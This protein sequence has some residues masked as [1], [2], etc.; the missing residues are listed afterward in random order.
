MMS[1][2]DAP[3]SNIEPPSTV[4]VP[5]WEAELAAQALDEAHARDE[6]ARD[7]MKA[8]QLAQRVQLIANADLELA[9]LRRDNELW[10]RMW[11]GWRWFG[12]NQIT[13]LYAYT[14]TMRRPEWLL[15]IAALFCFVMC[16]TTCAIKKWVAGL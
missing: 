16:F 6:A 15:V 4:P 14:R 11:S 5:P 12:V 1:E 8:Q 9:R 7:D 13:L 3:A 2:P 10:S